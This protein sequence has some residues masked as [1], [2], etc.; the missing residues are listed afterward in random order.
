M[1]L[2]TKPTLHLGELNTVFN[3]SD[4]EENS[5]A[6]TVGTGD[7]RYLKLS[8]GTETGFVTFNN[9]ISTNTIN[10]NVSFNNAITVPSITLSGS[11]TASQTSAQI[12][13]YKSVALA[14][15]SGSIS[16]GTPS[17]PS[18][19]VISI[20]AG[21]WIVSYYHNITCT[22][23]ITFS[24]IL[25]GLTTASNGTYPN[26]ATVSTST[27]SETLASG[28]KLISQ[29]Y[30]VRNSTTTNW[31]APIT[32]TYTTAGTPTIN[33]GLSAVRLA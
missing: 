7:N 32:I 4:F 30:V 29:T 15:T 13:Y 12:G 31:Y 18:Y 19:N 27:A 3:P 24:Y 9:G 5:T 16:N 26:Q 11:G 20:P 1:S 28:N 21:V 10:G 33:F 6:L 14:I 17:T 23:S 25:H 2:Y 22:A 8:G